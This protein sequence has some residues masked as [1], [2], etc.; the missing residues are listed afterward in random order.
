MRLNNLFSGTLL[1]LMA[2]SL[3]AFAAD[4]AAA[5]NA[6]PAE[7]FAAAQTDWAKLQKDVQGVVTKFRAAKDDAEREKLKKEYEGIVAKAPEI[8]KNLRASAVALYTETPNKDP[9]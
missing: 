5:D 2:L 9:E 8:L 1:V 6:A 4:D 7:Q 3:T